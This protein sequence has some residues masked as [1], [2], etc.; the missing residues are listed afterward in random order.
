[1][2]GGL[3]RVRGNQVTWYGGG[4]LPNEVLAQRVTDIQVDRSGGTRRI[5]VGFRGDDSTPGSIGI[6]SGP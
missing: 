1:M 6:Y 4:V 3:S 2:G 5:L